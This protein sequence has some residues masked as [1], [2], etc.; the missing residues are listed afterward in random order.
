MSWWIHGSI[1]W[2]GPWLDGWMEGM[3]WMLFL[4]TSALPS[5]VIVLGRGTTRASPR[6]FIFR[7][8]STHTRTG[9]VWMPAAQG[10]LDLGYPAAIALSPPGAIAFVAARHGI[11]LS[12]RTDGH[13]GG[14]R[15]STNASTAS[16]L[17]EEMSI[18]VRVRS[19]HASLRHTRA[20]TNA[21]PWSRRSACLVAWF[22]FF[23]I[24]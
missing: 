20:S 16:R 4:S 23:S 24:A 12:M 15:T 14:R 3:E 8:R 13:Y 10:K 21:L 2:M 18:L 7:A 1:G 22:S 5:V 11:P 9:L 6:R 19:R 17:C